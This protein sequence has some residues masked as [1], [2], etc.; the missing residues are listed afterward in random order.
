M[1]GSD[2]SV[3]SD[4][5]TSPSH[6]SHH[7][8]GGHSH[9]TISAS[10]SLLHSIILVITLGV[11]TLFEGMAIGLLTDMD[12]LITLVIAVFIH[13]I[14]CSIALGVNIS[15][16]SLSKAASLAICCVFS[17]MMPVGIAIGIGLGEIRGFPG[18]LLTAI[19]QGLATGT[20]MYVLFMEIVPSIFNSC[21]SIVQIIL[22]F[23]GCVFMCLVI[24]F[25]HSHEH[26]APMS[27]AVN[28]T[29]SP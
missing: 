11:H 27:L 15:Q 26:E 16:Q 22:M 21:N 19:M 13:E 17:C 14:C 25:T 8:G 29:F 20:F 28:S 3:N 23:V 9:N 6:H 5:A 4:R 1:S 10:R 7:H 18:L 24:V 2:N 12:L